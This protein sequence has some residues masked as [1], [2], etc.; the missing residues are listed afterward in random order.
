MVDPDALIQWCSVPAADLPGHPDLTVPIDVLDTPEDVYRTIAKEMFHELSTNDSNGVD[1]RWI[2]PCGPVGQYPIFAELVNASSVS[3]DR[4]HVFHMDDFLDWQGRP[5]PEEHAFSMRGAMLR[6]F[7]GSLDDKHVVPEA[8]RHFPDVFR[9]DALSEAIA[10]VGGVDTAWGGIGYRGHVAFNEPP[11]SPWHILTVQQ[12]AASKTR[13]VPLNDDTMIAIS[14]RNAGGLAQVVPPLG[15]T[16][17]MADLLAAHRV[18]LFSATGAWKQAVIRV[19]AFSRPSIDYPVTLFA[20]HPNA[21][22]LVDAATATSPLKDAG[23]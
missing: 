1:T 22:I 16:I 18:R 17:G 4:L 19:A 9:P 23:V 7:Y 8:N 5:L 13:I 20:D 12:F 2:L 11:R 15:I 3:M 6:D 14:Q 21:S 10:A